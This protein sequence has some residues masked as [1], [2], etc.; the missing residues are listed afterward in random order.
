MIN[1]STKCA[2]P[3]KDNEKWQKQLVFNEKRHRACNNSENN[4]DQKIYA[5]AARM[6]SNDERSSEN[7][8]DRTQLTNWILD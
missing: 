3:P 2:N 6:S 8:G 1:T 7:Y 4:S 5:S